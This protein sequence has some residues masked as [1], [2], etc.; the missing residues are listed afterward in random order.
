MLPRRV[1]ALSA[2]CLMLAAWR[3]LAALPSCAVNTLYVACVWLVHD[4]VV[5]RACLSVE[6]SRNAIAIGP[7]RSLKPLR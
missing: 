5:P 3:W 6:T 2:V 4:A 1:P 7:N